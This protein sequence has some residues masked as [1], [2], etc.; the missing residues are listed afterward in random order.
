MDRIVDS[1]SEILIKQYPTH[2]QFVQEIPKGFTRPS[3]FIEFI[4]SHLEDLNKDIYKDTFLFKITYFIEKDEYGAVDK[5]KQLQ[6]VLKLRNLFNI[7]SIPVVGTDRHMKVEGLE[8]LMIGEEIA[9]H[10]ELSLTNSREI[11]KNYQ[12]MGEVILNTKTD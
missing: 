7:L 5:M 8:I 2:V 10:L 1:I 4:D 9:L 12:L 6:E 3:F 11:I